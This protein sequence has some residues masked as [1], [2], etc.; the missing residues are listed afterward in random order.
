MDAGYRRLKI[1]KLAHSLAVRIHRMSLTLPTFE[2]YEEGSQIRRSSKSV[3]EQIVEGFALRKYKN[4]F[5]HYLWRA[6]GSCEETQEHLQYLF[7]TESWKD[8]SSFE[9]ALSEYKKLSGMLFRFIQSVEESHD[10]PAFLKEP[11]IQYEV[12]SLPVPS[13]RPENP[14]PET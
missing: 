3:S 8:E 11:E 13:I 14:N 1:Y 5:L 4:E 10:T 12:D 9:E 7:D 2:K 6:Y